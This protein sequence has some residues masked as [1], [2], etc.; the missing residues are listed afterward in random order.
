MIQ[1]KE[2][3][4]TFDISATMEKDDLNTLYHF[5][6]KRNFLR[7]SLGLH[8]AACTCSSW[9]TSWCAFPWHTST[10]ATCTNRRLGNARQTSWNCLFVTS[11]FSSYVVHKGG[12]IIYYVCTYF[13]P[14]SRSRIYSVYSCLCIYVPAERTDGR[15]EEWA[16]LRVTRS[17]Q[18]WIN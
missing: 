7:N 3:K 5:F 17:A 13:P 10:H 16:R 1:E 9:Q 2:N 18:M 8:M 15:S 14:S 12:Y 11:F 4:R 6:F